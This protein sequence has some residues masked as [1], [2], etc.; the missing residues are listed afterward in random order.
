MITYI[1]NDESTQ[2]AKTGNLVIIDAVYHNDALTLIVQNV[3]NK[4]CLRLRF[5]HPQLSSN[6]VDLIGLPLLGAVFNRFVSIYRT[7]YFDTAYAVFKIDNQTQL[8][9]RGG[10]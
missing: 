9:I 2:L 8:T 3:T 6:S 1:L 4:K 5:D 7:K 10:H